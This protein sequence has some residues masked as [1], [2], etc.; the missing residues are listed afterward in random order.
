MEDWKTCPRCLVSYQHQ[1]NVGQLLCLH[2][3]GYYD[4]DFGYSCCNRKFRQW[5]HSS[6]SFAMQQTGLEVEHRLS[7]EPRGCTPCDHGSDLVSIN[8]HEDHELAVFLW[9]K[10]GSKSSELIPGLNMET[11]QVSRTSN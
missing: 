4:R 9:E 2:H 11:L 6:R 1:N 3:P 5:R 10:Y 7:P 8:L